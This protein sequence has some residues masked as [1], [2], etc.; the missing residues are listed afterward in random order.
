MATFTLTIECDNAA[1]QDG[2]PLVEIGAILGRLATT[3]ALEQGNDSGT[4]RDTNGNRCGEY[5]Y[6]TVRATRTAYK[7]RA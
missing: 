1:F 4:L 6:V 2:D 5:S 3:F 7:R